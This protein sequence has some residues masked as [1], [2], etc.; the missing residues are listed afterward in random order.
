MATVPDLVPLIGR[1]I[2]GELPV[3]EH[4]TDQRII[5]AVLAELLVTPLRKLSLEHVAERAGV[6]RMTVYRRF[7]DRQRVIEATFA[8]EVSRFLAAIVAA[9]DPGAPPDERI[10]DAFATALTLIHSDPLVAHLLATNPG[11]LLETVLAEDG[12]VIAAGSAFIAAQIAQPGR[13]GPP[14]GAQRTGELLARLFVALVLMPP[15]S[16]DLTK[17]NEA[18]RLAQEMV[19]PLVVRGGS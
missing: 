13:K 18:R 17:P 2:A 15:P 14:A 7:G 8:R 19:V 16:V 5:D 10:T 1:S 9:D 3:S 11:E 6:T 4:E 12:F